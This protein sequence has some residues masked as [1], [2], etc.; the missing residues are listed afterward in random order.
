MSLNK[1]LQELSLDELLQKA[2]E[3]QDDMQSV[4]TKLATACVTGVAGNNKEVQIKIN[5]KFQ[6]ISTSIADSAYTN[7]E[8]LED[9]ITIAINDAISQLELIAKN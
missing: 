7:K 9:L 4:Q 2:R 8:Q 1:P 6:A 3:I 5:G